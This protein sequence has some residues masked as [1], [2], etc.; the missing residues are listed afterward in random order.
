[1]PLSPRTGRRARSCGLKASASTPP[2]PH[3]VT[4]R[5]HLVDVG[6]IVRTTTSPHASCARTV[7]ATRFDH[8]ASTGR[9]G[10]VS[11]NFIVEIQQITGTDRGNP[12][13]TDSDQSPGPTGQRAFCT[14]PFVLP[15]M[16]LRRRQ[17]WQSQALRTR[18]TVKQGRAIHPAFPTRPRTSS[19]HP[20]QVA[21]ITADTPPAF[22]G[23]PVAGERIATQRFRLNGPF[24]DPHPLSRVEHRA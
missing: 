2:A 13:A 9:I 12:H 6:R 7:R 10:R 3:M 19:R 17:G 24:E 18:Q 15:R 4:D 22:A 5:V 23:R 16:V 14:V 11:E 1:M 20:V 8:E 21:A